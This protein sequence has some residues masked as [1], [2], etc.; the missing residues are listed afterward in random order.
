MGRLLLIKGEN[1][2]GK[3]AYAEKIAAKAARER[4]YIATMIPV[5]RENR[6]R[7][8]KHRRAREGM[9]FKTLELSYSVGEADVSPRG[10]VL[11]EDVSNLLANVM[12]EKGGSAD[13]VYR[14][15]LSLGER[16]GV[17]IAVTISG[18]T[19][20]F[21]EE[22]EGYIRALDFLN[23]RL[24]DAADAAVVMKDKKPVYIKGRENDIV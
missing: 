1:D 15:I 12:F 7:I 9:G 14:D 20:S 2:S 19:G 6:M 8:E 4:Y 5:T 21:D 16:C 13:E 11:L 17:L 18:I 22:T 23:K 24:F 10:A 3:S